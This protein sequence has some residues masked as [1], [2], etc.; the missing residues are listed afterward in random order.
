MDL[1]KVCDYVDK[2]R[3]AF[4]EQLLIL[5]RQPSIS[6]QNIGV[7]ECKNLLVDIIKDTGMSTE[8][9]QTKGHP[10][11]YAEHMSDPEKQTILFYGHYDV[12]PPDPL[13]EWMSPPF[14]PTLRD[15]KIFARGAGDN[16]GQLMAQVLAVKSFRDVHGNLPVNVKFVFEGEEEIGSPNIA[17]FVTAHQEKLK[18]DLIYTSDGPLD[19]GGKPMVLLGVRGIL[20]VELTAYGAKWD[21]HSGKY[22]DITQRQ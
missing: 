10:V 5:L 11:I 15:G 13:E 14:E 7:V 19:A 1:D 20:Y 17:S 6:A 22:N 8:V 9:I 16:K 18:A 21:N 2:N 4:L 3:D 12:Q